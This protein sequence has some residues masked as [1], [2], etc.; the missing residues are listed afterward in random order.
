MI[1]EGYEYR[2][3]TPIKLQQGWN[4]ILIK[5]PVAS[6]K[7]NDWQSPVK[8]MFTCIPVTTGAIHVDSLEDIVFDPDGAK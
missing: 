2:K 8:W 4:T 6:F 1:D 5:A 3:P 7:S